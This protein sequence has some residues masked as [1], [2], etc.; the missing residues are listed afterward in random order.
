MFYAVV[1][2]AAEFATFWA[3]RVVIT[4]RVA[5]MRAVS[6]AAREGAEAARNGHQF[7]N[8]TGKLEASIQGKNNTSGSDDYRSEIVASEHYASYVENGRGPVSRFDPGGL[9]LA[10][11]FQN[12]NGEFIFR[13]RVRAAAPKPF[14][15]IAYLKAERV[16]Q[17]EVENGVARAQ[18]LLDR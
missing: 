2:N 10:L 6:M 3:N 14:M 11:R 1:E 15:G 18:E 8:R 13:V 4:I 5:T 12:Q 16:L 9:R 17:R 7:T